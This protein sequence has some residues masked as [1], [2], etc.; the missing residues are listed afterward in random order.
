MLFATQHAIKAQI[1]V[2]KQNDSKL[3]FRI[4]HRLKRLV[5]SAI[6]QKIM[7]DYKSTTIF[8]QDPIFCCF[9][10]HSPVFLLQIALLLL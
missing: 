5:I 2:K 9:V 3:T 7:V 6:Y 8:S 10:T 4:N 1:K